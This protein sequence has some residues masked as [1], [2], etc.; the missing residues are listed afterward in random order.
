MNVLVNLDLYKPVIAIMLDNAYTNNVTIK[1]MWPNLD[2]FYVKL[3]HIR[4][5]LHIV[6]LVVKDG[7]DLVQESIEKIRQSIIY[8]SNNISQVALF[9]ILCRV[10]N[11]RPRIFRIDES[12][13]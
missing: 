11:K 2:G 10:C 4:C 1:L 9:K 6:S 3:F 5:T 8:L 12:H 13:R 7:L